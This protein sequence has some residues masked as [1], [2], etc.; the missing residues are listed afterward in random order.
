MLAC[1]STMQKLEMQN[2]VKSPDLSPN[3]LSITNGLDS[4]SVSSAVSNKRKRL[5]FDDS[6]QSC[7]IPNEK[8]FC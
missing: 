6:D 5:T 3:P 8:R 2:S 1:Y 7:D 4:S